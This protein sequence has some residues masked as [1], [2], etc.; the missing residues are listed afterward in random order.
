MNV[1][2]LLL[3][4]Q[5][6]IALLNQFRIDINDLVVNDEDLL[7]HKK[8]HQKLPVIQEN[9]CL[10]GKNAEGTITLFGVL[11]YNWINQLAV[12]ELKSFEKV[13]LA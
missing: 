8:Q 9:V 1:K 11:H 5:N 12:F 13:A 7:L 4:G 2:E 6:F 10:E 3:K